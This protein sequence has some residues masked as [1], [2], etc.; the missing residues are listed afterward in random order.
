MG[1][2]YECVDD[3]GNGK[4]EAVHHPRRQTQE[5]DDG[6]G[7][8]GCDRGSASRDCNVCG[9]AQ[10]ACAVQGMQECKQLGLYSTC[11][12]GLRPSTR[13]QVFYAKI[14]HVYF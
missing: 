11:S 2:S 3:P 13:G 6:N 9:L 7:R 4:S 14:M 8:H 5:V 1:R 12:A 10:G